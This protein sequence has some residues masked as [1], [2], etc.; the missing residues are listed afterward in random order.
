MIDALH[1]CRYRF[2]DDACGA[3]QSANEHA[4]DG[5]DGWNVATALDCGYDSHSAVSKSDGGRN[6]E[7]GMQTV[8]DNGIDARGGQL[9]GSKSGGSPPP[10]YLI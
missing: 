6:D 7:S 5:D 10:C 1:A 3:L 4:D 2:D 9:N 8:S